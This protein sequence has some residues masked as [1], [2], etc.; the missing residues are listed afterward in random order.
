MPQGLEMG[1]FTRAKKGLR[2]ATRVSWDNLTN[3]ATF[4][5]DSKQQYTNLAQALDE[6]LREIGF[7]HSD[8]FVYRHR[9]DPDLIVDL[10]DTSR[11]IR[12]KGY[13]CPLL[14]T[15]RPNTRSISALLNS[16]RRTYFAGRLP[17]SVEMWSL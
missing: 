2:Y 9:Q 17:D 1:K 15:P 6:L 12:Y 8:E 3:I 14:S 10:R 7:Q 11:A 13:S 5:D 16:I 4:E